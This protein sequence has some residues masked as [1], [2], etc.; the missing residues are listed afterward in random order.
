MRITVLFQLVYWD[1]K[2]IYLEH[3]F[4]TVS[5]KFVRAIIISKLNIIG[6]K[7]NLT[8]L[9]KILDPEIEELE[10]PEDLKHWLQYID[11]S[12]QKLKKLN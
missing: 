11:A 9:L 1:D 6:L 8:D 3:K 5:D 7:M 10:A 2:A 4:I 12:S